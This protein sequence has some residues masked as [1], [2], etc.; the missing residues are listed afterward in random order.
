MKFFL[1][2]FNLNKNTKQIKIEEPQLFYEVGYIPYNEDYSVGYF[3][4][5][6]IKDGLFT[7]SKCVLSHVFKN[8]NYFFYYNQQY[9]YANYP[10]QK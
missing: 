8:F 1:Y 3:N 6:L 7:K 5:F 4:R 9:I 2:R 10:G